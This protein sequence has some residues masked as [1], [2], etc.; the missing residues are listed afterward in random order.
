MH[1]IYNNLNVLSVQQ[2]HPMNAQ[3]QKDFMRLDHLQK[4]TK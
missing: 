4:I 2:G 3:S 1:N